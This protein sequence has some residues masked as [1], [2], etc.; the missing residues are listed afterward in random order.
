MSFR[1]IMLSMTDVFMHKVKIDT[2]DP[3]LESTRSKLK[4]IPLI[5]DS[6]TNLLLI[7][8]GVITPRTI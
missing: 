3:N 6:K 5:F 2:F 1:S 8:H 7:I 4:C